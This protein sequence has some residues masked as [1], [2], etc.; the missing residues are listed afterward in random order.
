MIDFPIEK[1]IIA[2]P[3]VDLGRANL[4]AEAAGMLVWMLLPCRGVRQ[5]AVGAV[6][7]FGLPY[8]ACHPAII[9]RSRHVI[10]PNSLPPSMTYYSNP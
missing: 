7:I 10:Q 8:V 9:R 3:R 4:T 1:F 2:G 6:E 5:S